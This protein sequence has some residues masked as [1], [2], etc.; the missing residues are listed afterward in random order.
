MEFVSETNAKTY[1]AKFGINGDKRTY[2]IVFEREPNYGDE[3]VTIKTEKEGFRISI[4]KEKTDNLIFD[5]CRVIEYFEKTFT[6]PTEDAL[7]SAFEDIVIT[8]SVL[9]NST[10]DVTWR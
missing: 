7:Y 1:E 8:L 10:F 2:R 4:P 9:Y 5:A 3:Y 6:Y